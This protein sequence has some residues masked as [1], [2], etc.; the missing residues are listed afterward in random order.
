M[1][2]SIFRD[3]DCGDP[4][5]VCRVYDYVIDL[6]YEH[7]EPTIREVNIAFH[8]FELKLNEFPYIF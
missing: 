4:R 6:L 7:T 3:I 1:L 8:N 5:G 2:C